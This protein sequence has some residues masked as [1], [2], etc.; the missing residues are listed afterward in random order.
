MM[1][2]NVYRDRLAFVLTDR[3]MVLDGF[4]SEGDATG[5]AVSLALECRALYSI[6]YLRP[7]PTSRSPGL[8]EG[9]RRIQRLVSSR[10]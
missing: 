5:A 3:R 6:S 1:E 7:E 9:S 8:C 2:F 10:C 4:V